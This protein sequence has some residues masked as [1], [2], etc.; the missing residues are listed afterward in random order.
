MPKDGQAA[1][2]HCNDNRMILTSRQGTA[3]ARNVTIGDES[4]SSGKSEADRQTDRAE[5]YKKGDRDDG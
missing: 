4:E 3:D 1:R 2:A 5:E